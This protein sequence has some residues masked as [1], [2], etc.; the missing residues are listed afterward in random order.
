LT[1][2]QGRSRDACPVCGEHRLAIGPDQR[3][4]LRQ[5]RPYDELIAMG[6]PAP[7][8]EPSIECLAC[9]SS[10]PNLADFRAAERGEGPPS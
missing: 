7:D 3:P 2:K 4:D 5:I 8:F 6:D 10:W 1:R 9:E